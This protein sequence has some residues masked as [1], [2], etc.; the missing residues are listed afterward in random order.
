MAIHAEICGHVFV[1]G[2]I[3]FGRGTEQETKI[4]ASHAWMS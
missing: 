2:L 4:G 1:D 3:C